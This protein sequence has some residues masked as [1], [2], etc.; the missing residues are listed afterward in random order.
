MVLRP[1]RSADGDR[2]HEAPFGHQRVADEAD[3]FGSLHGLRGLVA[4]RALGNLERGLDH[5]LR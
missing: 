2:R 4:V 3:V 1:I 5:D